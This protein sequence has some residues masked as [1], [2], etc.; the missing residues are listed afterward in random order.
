ML[1][2]KT[3][4]KIINIDVCERKTANQSHQKS[5]IS[6]K[7]KGVINSNLA[8]KN[9]K[10]DR[11]NPSIKK[12]VDQILNKNYTNFNFNITNYTPFENI[13]ISI[14]SSNKKKD[15]NIN[16]ITKTEPNNKKASGKISLNKKLL[17]TPGILNIKIKENNNNRSNLMTSNSQ[18]VIKTKLDHS[19]RISVTEVNS[20]NNN[21]KNFQNN[22]ENFFLGK[23]KHCK[24]KSNKKYFCVYTEE[25]EGIK[26]NLFKSKYRSFYSFK[27][28]RKLSR[29]NDNEYRCNTGETSA[30]K[31]I[32]QEHIKSNN[33]DDYL[34]FQMSKKNK[35][36]K[37]NMSKKIDTRDVLLKSN[38]IPNSNYKKI[39]RKISKIKK[40]ERRG[41]KLKKEISNK[42]NIYYGPE[43]CFFSLVENIQKTKN[44][45][46]EF[47][48]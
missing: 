13:N 40:P 37:N 6:K 46:S 45:I 17:K 7:V 32:K 1:H 36:P 12:K 48:A 25:G 44:I 18:N 23:L 27:D 8:L 42:K 10:R 34:I 14:N 39:N 28:I 47:N 15:D 3:K 22:T 35:C 20:Y 31:K 9:Q 30:K 2:Q 33:N 41:S 29:D 24:S 5:N 26:K 19:H 21:E 4:Y 16:I 43:M 11:V 38:D